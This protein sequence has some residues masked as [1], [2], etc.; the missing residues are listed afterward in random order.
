MSTLVDNKIA[1]LHVSEDI[2]TLQCSESGLFS[3]FRID[4]CL[5]LLVLICNTCQI[6]EEKLHLILY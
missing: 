3:T 2:S 4:I 1:L 5:K 6:T